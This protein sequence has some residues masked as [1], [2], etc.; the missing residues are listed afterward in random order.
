MSGFLFDPA[1]A[2]ERDASFELRP[3]FHGPDVTPEDE[4]RL[5]T[6][7]GRVRAHMADGEWHTL[8]E[9]ADAC[10]GS[11]ASVSARLRD[12]RRPEHG[13]LEVQ[14]KRLSAGV[15]LYRVA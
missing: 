14:R 8:R 15:W 3:R 4:E 11:E 1:P 7:L 2:P 9:V 12:L 5:G 6:L 10:R 13:G